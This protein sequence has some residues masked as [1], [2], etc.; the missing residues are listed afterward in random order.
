MPRAQYPQELVEL[1]QSAPPSETHEQ[2]SDRLNAAGH[3]TTPRTVKKWRLAARAARQDAAR[4]ILERHVAEHVT[5]A[6][7]DLTELR[8]QAR[9]TYQQERE[10][11]N[12]RLWLDAIRTELE[13]VKPPVDPA[14]EMAD[15]RETLLR[16]LSALTAAAGA[17]VVHRE[18][19]T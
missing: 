19:D 14:A 13:H 10:A 6:L 1:I 4:E 3:E 15:A 5:D 8:A 12:G 17:G 2:V 18:S 16:R 7:S 9:E 11:R